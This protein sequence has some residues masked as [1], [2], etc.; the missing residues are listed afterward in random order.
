MQTIS[1]DY[2]QG[3]NDYSLETISI[4]NASFSCPIL[5]EI[6]DVDINKISKVLVEE[7]HATKFILDDN[8]IFVIRQ[9]EQIIGVVLTDTTTYRSKALVITDELPNS[10]K[11]YNL[12]KDLKAP[13]SDN[14]S[15]TFTIYYLDKD[16]LSE[17]TIELPHKKLDCI[18]PDL[19][20]DIDPEILAKEFIESDDNLLIV[21]GDPGTGKT[22]FIKYLTLQLYRL[23][24]ISN[25]SY[26]K[27]WKT[28]NDSQFWPK[29]TGYEP[30]LLILDDLDHDLTTQDSKRSEF[31]SNLLSYL[32]GVLT[33]KS[34]KVIISTNQPIGTIDAA[35]LRSGRCFDCIELHK[36]KASYAKEIWDNLDLKEKFPFKKEFISQAEFMA[37]INNLQ[38]PNKT[39]KYLK[40]GNKYLSI[41]EKL[42]LK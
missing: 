1:L 3:I 2:Y 17:L 31:V 42:N 16:N 7:L 6:C 19:Y 11:I 36:L 14:A 25:I 4:I 40:N 20:P 35:L 26:A 23:K 34:N 18:N 22:S 10:E 28:M 8:Q 9:R 24:N 5:T 15:S 30:P 41:E 27:D 37:V 38:K 21:H 39:R 13:L 12:I 32:D 33:N 29:I